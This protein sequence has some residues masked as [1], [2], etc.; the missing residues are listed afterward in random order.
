MVRQRD[1]EALSV[2][3]EIADTIFASEE[4]KRAAILIG[5]RAYRRGVQDGRDASLQQIRELPAKAVGQ[6]VIATGCKVRRE[7]KWRKRIADRREARRAR[8]GIT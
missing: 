3:A 8:L 2:A 5:A 1:T 6:A 4:V 7:H